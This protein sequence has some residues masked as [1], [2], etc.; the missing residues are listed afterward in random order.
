MDS[1]VRHSIYPGPALVQGSL[2]LMNV[3]RRISDVVSMIREQE[4]SLRVSWLHPETI[5][6]LGR[7]ILS[8]SPKALNPSDSRADPVVVAIYIDDNL[9][10]YSAQGY[11]T[12][13]KEIRYKNQFENIQDMA[14]TVRKFGHSSLLI[15]I[16]TMDSQVNWRRN[17]FTTDAHFHQSTEQAFKAAHKVPDNKNIDAG[18]GFPLFD[19]GGRLVGV[20]C[21]SGL[22]DAKNHDLIVRGIRKYLH[23]PEDVSQKTEEVSQKTEEVLQ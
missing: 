4:F 14:Y 19:G 15:G 21:V 3:R 7:T 18:G 11:E 6:R 20:I 10:F 23:K 16:T 9:I 17:F 5:D 2:P 1:F 13:F 22:G 8:L 12:L